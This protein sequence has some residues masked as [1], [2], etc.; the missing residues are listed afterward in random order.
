MGRIPLMDATLTMAPPPPAR[1]TGGGRPDPVEGRP[2]GGVDHPVVGPV[3]VPV[4]RPGQP[5]PALLTRM[6]S[7]PSSATPGP[8]PSSTASPSAM[9]ATRAGRRPPRPPWRPLG[10]DVERGHRGP[11]VPQP[12]PGGPADPRPGPGDQGP[13]A[14]EQPHQARHRLGRTA[15]R[16][17]EVHDL[18]GR[19]EVRPDQG[20]PGGEGVRVAEADEVIVEGLPLDQQQVLVGGLDAPVE[21]EG[22]EPGEAAMT[23]G[24]RPP[25][26]RTPGG[27]GP[28]GDQGMLE[29]HGADAT[30]AGVRNTRGGPGGCTGGR[31]GRVGRRRAIER[32]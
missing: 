27:P 8:R 22:D 3:A 11:F 29:D 21:S 18:G 19:L 10:V 23:G 24:P 26:P 25:P 16:Q 31:R 9:S 12:E 6:Q 4:E 30:G 28:D 13:M 17:V 7:P 1:M 15:A 14:V 5:I 20:P 2:H 32:E